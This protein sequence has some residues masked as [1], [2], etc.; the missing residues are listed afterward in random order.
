MDPTGTYAFI[1]DAGNDLVRRLDLTS[2]A[3]T[4]MGLSAD[5]SFTDLTGVSV[6]PSGKYL[7]TTQLNLVRRIDLETDDVTEVSTSADPVIS[8][9]FGI[10]ADPSGRFLYV[11]DNTQNLVR[12]IDLASGDVTSMGS[13]PA[14]PLDFL[15]LL[16]LIQTD[17]GSSWRTTATT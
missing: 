12:Q 17:K 15:K 2:G 10:S 14:L 13:R 5:P 7:Y 3:V 11:A 8:D 9:P 1:A 16:Q 6:D 4:E